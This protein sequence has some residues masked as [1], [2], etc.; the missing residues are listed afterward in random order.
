MLGEA[1]PVAFQHSAHFNEVAMLTWAIDQLVDCSVDS[2]GAADTQRRPSVNV[3]KG[4]KCD[5]N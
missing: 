3:I 5:N 1:R 4:V 2:T